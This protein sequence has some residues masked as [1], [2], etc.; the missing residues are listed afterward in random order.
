MKRLVLTLSVLIGLSSFVLTGST[1]VAVGRPGGSGP[2]AAPPKT[3]VSFVDALAAAPAVNPAVPS[4][5]MAPPATPAPVTKAGSAG[6]PQPANLTTP[7]R[8]ENGAPLPVPA[9]D[10]YAAYGTGTPL[11]ADALQ[12]AGRRLAD[13]EVAFSGASFAS[14]EMKDGL[15][16]EMQ[17]VVAP[18]L[19]PHSGFGRGSGFELGLGIGNSEK[20]QLIL[21][22]LAEMAAPPSAARITK[23]IG[24]ITVDPILKA[25]LLRGQAQSRVAGNACTIGSDL[26]YGSGYAADVNLLNAGDD[27]IKALVKTSAPDPQR[28]VSQSISRT[29]LIMRDGTKGADLRFGLLSETR[30]TIAPVTFFAGS[31]HQFTIEVL[32]EWVLRGIADGAKGSL[33]YGPADK[34]PETPVLRIIDGHGKVMT[35][36]TLQQ[37][38]GDKGLE[39]NIPGIA[40]IVIG[41]DPRAVDGDAASN[42]VQT[43]TLVLGAADVVRVR[44]LNQGDSHLA[45][46]R[47][48]H[49]E[50]G[51]A[52]PADGI[53][54]PGIG[55]VLKAEPPTVKPGEKFDWHLTVSNPNDCKLDHIKVVDVIKA[56]DG[57]KYDVDS[58]E[59]KAD[60]VEPAKVVFED[61]G[62]LEPG[63]NKDLR[64]RV[65]V[66]DRS[67]SGHFTDHALATGVCGPA[68]ANGQ[69]AAEEGARSA[70]G[71]AV[72]FEG[73][74]TLD[75]PD[76]GIKIPVPIG[77]I[78]RADH[79]SVKLGEAFK[80]IITVS[81]PNSCVLSKLKLVD[82]IT[83][84]PGVK[85]DIV[86][87]KPTADSVEAGA[88]KITFA[89][90]G[91][92]APGQSKDVEIGMKVSDQ[93]SSGKFTD[94]AI[95]TGVCGPAVARGE[96]AAGG[97]VE[98]LQVPSEGHV[99]LES[100][101]VNNEV[102]AAGLPGGPGTDVL[103]GEK[104]RDGAGLPAVLPRTG[105]VLDVL[106]PIALLGTGT[107]LRR[108]NRRHRRA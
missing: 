93:S 35:Q 65:K 45:D 31:E 34:S 43:G 75:A 94:T 47:L 106:W 107:A 42:P 41:E 44:L 72:P 46:V 16:N 95:A 13:V 39:V 37:F 68:A 92:L 60:S 50:V 82:T 56:T 29:R 84:T 24:P 96:A 83:T 20:N 67:A 87:T 70:A 23:Q 85:Y 15:L 90:I 2:P 36:L 69:A 102:T 79:T 4:P 81:N 18:R 17:R 10:V 22:D 38:L 49:M 71:E 89:D 100:P 108:L 53:R 59:P 101:S 12:Y 1:A 5:S 73:Q 58:T 25:T 32:G 99:T 78:K 48:G 105:G 11:Y 74:V 8:R 52:V 64:I 51:M 27:F 97:E 77:M 104:L 86:S 30:Q 26:A 54:C 33:F 98:S 62:S 55:M 21:A 66:S 63:A 40:E 57:V 6:K 103:A 91:G 7:V 76:V 80:W 14:N 19:A 9:P 61:I 3:G 88:G 28:A